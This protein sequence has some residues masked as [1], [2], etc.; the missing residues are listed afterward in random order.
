MV[1]LALPGIGHAADAAASAP[2]RAASAAGAATPDIGARLYEIVQQYASVGDHRTGTEADRA[3]LAWFSAELQR[4]GAEVQRMPFR[5]NRYDGASEVTIAGSKVASLPLYYQGLGDLTDEHPY[6]ATIPVID[7]DKETP[8]LADV[9][10]QARVAGARSVVIA[11]QG[12]LGELQTPDRVP[13]AGDGMPVVLV[14]GRV[15]DALQKGPVQLAFSGRIVAGA[16]DNIV[17]SFGRPSGAP[18]VIDTPLTGWFS[19]AAE[20]GTGIAIALALAEHIAP[21]HPVVVIGTPGHELLPHLGLTTYL[22]QNHIEPGL[23]VHL[24]ANVA[25]G[26]KDESGHWT[27]VDTRAVGVRSDADTYARMRPALATLG[28]TPYF[29]PPRFLGEAALWA[30][31]VKSPML[32]IAGVGPQFHSP[33]DTPENTTSPAL[34]RQAYDAL[35]G[36]VDAWL[37]TKAP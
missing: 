16:S 1:A 17:A 25:L 11:T 23:V 7:N 4:R 20:R 34:L 24:G 5:F 32:S 33:A 37:D 28:L 15:A 10:A 12:P 19:C 8:A 21:R 14:P 22:Q 31:A 27:F 29:N 18:I 2:A 6:V 9:L 13:V 30:N 3:T 26:R 35:A 36:A